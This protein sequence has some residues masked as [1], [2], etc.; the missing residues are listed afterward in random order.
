MPLFMVAPD[1][2]TNEGRHLHT[3][4]QK[5]QRSSIITTSASTPDAAQEGF[6]L[7]GRFVE[8]RGSPPPHR[9]PGGKFEELFHI[10]PECGW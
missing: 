1:F 9:L 5:D 2:G 10:H 8:H 7:R 4:L 3:G 6:H